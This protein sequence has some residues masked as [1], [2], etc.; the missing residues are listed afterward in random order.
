MMPAVWARN[1]ADPGSMSPVRV[2]MTSPEAGVRPM[3]VSTHFHV[4]NRGHAGPGAQVRQDHS[5]GSR[6]RA[7]QLARAPP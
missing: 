5:A 1:R 4:V 6:F 3:V 7:R 2:P